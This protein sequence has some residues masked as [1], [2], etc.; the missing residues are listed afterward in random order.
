MPFR[1]IPERG[2][3]SENVSKPS[4]KQC[5]DVFQQ[6]ISGC[7]FANQ[8]GDLVEQTAAL[9]GKPRALPCCADVLA[10]EAACDDIDG[11][12]IGSKS[13]CGE[14]SNVIVNRNLGPVFAENLLRELFDLAESNGLKTA[15]ALKAK[16]E[17]ADACEQV[18]DAELTH[19]PQQP[20]APSQETGKRGSACFQR[21]RKSR[22]RRFRGLREFVQSSHFSFA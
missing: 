10:G 11:N 8:T 4:T 18:K 3:G 13:L 16:A 15:R 22:C 1:I 19:K 9:S 21:K 20:H 12:S 5:C 7:Q 6:D 17:A 14:C 2:Q